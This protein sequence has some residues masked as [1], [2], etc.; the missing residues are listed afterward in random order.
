MKFGF[1]FAASTLFSRALAH[2]NYDRLIHNGQI[3]GDYYTYIR[4]TSNSNS[5]ITDISSTDMRCNAGGGSGKST[6]TYTVKAGDE[7]GFMI[8]TEFGHPGPQQVY[9]SKAPNAAAD[10]DGSGS[11]TKIYSAT[12][13]AITSEGLQW[14]MDRVGSFRFTLPSQIPAGEYLVRAEG[15]ALHG[16]GSTGGAQWYMG[17]AQIKVASGGSGS[18]GNAVKIPGAYKA[19]DPGILINIYYPPPTNYTVPGPALW[20]SGTQETH[21]VKT[22]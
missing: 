15:L 8:N 12:T 1:V 11:W 9:I 2:W 17:C 6:Q 20:P 18:L 14:A 4:R 22:L 10:Y 3:V 19:N 21:S 16:A 5:P 13:K 7:I